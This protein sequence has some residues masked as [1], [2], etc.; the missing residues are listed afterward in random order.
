[1]FDYKSIKS[2]NTISNEFLKIGSDPQLSDVI[3]ATSIDIYPQHLKIGQTGTGFYIRDFA[4]HNR[5]CFV[6]TSKP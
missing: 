6:V 3:I 1:M 2:L 4:K 5:A